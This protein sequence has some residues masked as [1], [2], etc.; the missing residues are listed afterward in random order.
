MLFV[1]VSADPFDL[2]LPA[3]Y[4][5]DRYEIVICINFKDIDGRTIA[6]DY[7]QVVIKGSDIVVLL[8][9]RLSFIKSFNPGFGDIVAI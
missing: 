3:I 8:N 6:E 9:L 7:I 5:L 2:L 4:L 1:S